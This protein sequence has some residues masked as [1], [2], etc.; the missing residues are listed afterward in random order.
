MSNKF[1]LFF[2][3][4]FI[5]G[6]LFSQKIEKYIKYPTIKFNHS[7]YDGNI[8]EYYNYN[9]DYPNYLIFKL[10]FSYPQKIQNSYILGLGDD[11]INNFILRNDTAFVIDNLNNEY[12]FFI[13]NKKFYGDSIYV[14]SIGCVKNSYLKL[15]RILYDLELNDSLFE[16]TVRTLDKPK[17]WKDNEVIMPVGPK[18]RITEF[19]FTKKYGFYKISYNLLNEKNYFI[20]YYYPKSCRKIQKSRKRKYKA[21]KRKLNI[22][23]K[24]KDRGIKFDIRISKRFLRKAN[25]N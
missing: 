15:T 23:D 11:S 20:E 10:F 8:Y 7:Y 16:F 4:F 5:Y 24:S 19:I 6:I 13:L 1:F 3:S 12:L 18:I 25:K 21:E 14:K 22:Y 17:T 2:V 9:F